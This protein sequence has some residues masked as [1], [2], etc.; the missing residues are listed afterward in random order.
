MESMG[1]L[2][3]TSMGAL[4][5]I[6]DQNREGEERMSSQF[7]SAPMTAIPAISLVKVHMPVI[8]GKTW[9][10]AGGENSQRIFAGGARIGP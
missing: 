3:R 8:R 5:Q 2:S 1:A 9:S 10:R 6:D 4:S 7:G